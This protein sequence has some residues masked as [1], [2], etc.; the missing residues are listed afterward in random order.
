MTWFAFHGGY[1]T[2][3]LAGSQEKEAAAIGFHGYATK[4]AAEAKPNDVAFWQAPVL[5]LLEADYSYAVRA[6][7]QPG[8]PHATLTPGN[9]I[10][11]TGQAAG[12]YAGSAASGLL[13]G[14]HLGGISGHNLLVRGLKIVIGGVLL[15]AGIMKLAGADTA[16]LG[17]VGKLPGV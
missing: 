4:A 14:L 10:A 13:S 9:V 2:I 6:G 7:E 11:G 8:G 12:S 17:V 5:D 3:D 15:L 1:G 16:T